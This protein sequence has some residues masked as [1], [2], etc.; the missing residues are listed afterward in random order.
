MQMKALVAAR[1][2][3]HAGKD[4]K[5]GAVFYAKPGH[6]KVLVALKRAQY[7]IAVDPALAPVVD[8]APE[9]DV[10]GVVTEAVFEHS[11]PETVDTPRGRRVRAKKS[12]EGSQ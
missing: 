2:L 11:D 5:A 1:N 6:A 4:V 3:R 9:T 10:A 7:D 12:S 8:D